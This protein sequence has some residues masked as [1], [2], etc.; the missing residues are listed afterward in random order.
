MWEMTYFDDKLSQRSNDVL[1]RLDEWK[2][3]PNLLA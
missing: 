2:F 1:R 3:Y